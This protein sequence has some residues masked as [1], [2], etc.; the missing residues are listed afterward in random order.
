[1]P[2][3]DAHACGSYDSAGA[4]LHHDAAAAAAVDRVPPHRVRRAGRAL[5]GRLRLP[6]RRRRS[7]R[8]GAAGA[9]VAVRRP[10][11][12]RPG[13]GLGR[14]EHRVRAEL[15]GRPAAG[16]G[17]DQRLSELLFTEVLRLYLQ[18]RGT[19]RLTGWLAALRDPVVG[20]ALSLLHADPA[21][22]WTV[23]SWP[24]REVVADSARRPFQP[25]ARPPA[26]P[27]PDRVAAQPGLRAAADNR[28]RRG[29]GRCSVG[30]TSEEAFSRAFKRAFGKSPAHW[31]AG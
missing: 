10:A 16:R 27:L 12:G 3:G 19:S 1:M 11:P 21:R 23:A 31:R 6:A 17:S 7:L 14:G 2:Y 22:D 28:P 9:A 4:G 20:Q 25:A 29:R 30:Y 15:R 26:D 13:G 5:D 8:P 18:Q 24:R